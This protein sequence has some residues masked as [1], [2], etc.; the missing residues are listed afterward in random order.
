MSLLPLLFCALAAAQD[1]GV[2]AREVASF[3]R[4]AAAPVLVGLV[5]QWQFYNTKSLERELQRLPVTLLRLEGSPDPRASLG[6]ALSKTGLACGLLLRIAEG[7][8]GLTPVGDCGPGVTLPAGVQATGPPPAPAPPAE[9]PQALTP[10]RPDE[11]DL[12]RGRGYYLAGNTL[13]VASLA[14]PGLGCVVAEAYNSERDCRGTDSCMFAFLGFMTGSVALIPVATTGGAV[15]STSGLH[16]MHIDTPRAPLYSAL[17]GLAAFQAGF[18]AVPLLD[19]KGI[20]LGVT[21]LSVATLASVSQLVINVRRFR[22]ARLERP[23][24]KTG[25]D[26]LLQEDAEALV[27]AIGTENQG[28]E[29]DVEGHG[30]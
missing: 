6:A 28:D 19:G 24:L 29:I 13:A 3:Q 16:A 5:Q 20:G 8:I 10:R 22:G 11:W 23:W 2:V 7:R 27:G 25:N 12:R 18:L 15:L 30:G 14:L 4:R 1:P 9:E 17:V 26:Y 21:G